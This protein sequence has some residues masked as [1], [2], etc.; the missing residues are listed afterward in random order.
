V[1]GNLRRVG[2][3]WSRIDRGTG[4]FRARLGA[5]SSCFRIAVGSVLEQGAHDIRLSTLDQIGKL[6]W[7][8]MR[9]SI[10]PILVLDRAKGLSLAS[11]L[12]V[13]SKV[14]RT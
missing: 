11:Q 4:R 5:R 12:A 13:L 6:L 3:N 14:A 8:Q 1:A 7:R 10:E 9:R 2:K